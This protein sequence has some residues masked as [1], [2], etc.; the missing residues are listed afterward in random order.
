MIPS[1]TRKPGAVYLVLAALLTVFAARLL[2]TASEKS[3]TV[4][5][6]HYVGTAL[7]LW[8]SGD[9]HFARSL[10]FHPPLTFH[11]AGLPLLAL[12]LGQLEATPRLGGQLMHGSDPAPEL[13]RV[14]SRTPFI[15][16]ACWGAVLLFLWAREVAGT[17]AGLLAAFFY[18]FS[19]TLLANGS[20][21]HSDITVTVFFLQ[22]LYAF[23]R[24]WREPTGFRFGL[25]GLSLG[26]ALMAKLSALLLL[27]ILGILLAGIASQW[28]PLVREPSIHGPAA[29]PVR[30]GWAVGHFL[31]LLSLAVFV[32][33]LGYGGSFALSEG[34][35]GPH[36]SLTLPAYVHS[37]LFDFAANAQGR[38][39]FFFGEYSQQGWWYFLPA[40]YLLKT[41]LGFL[42]LLVFSI[43]SWR[44]SPGR[45]GIFLGT[46]ILVYLLVACVWLKVPLGLRYLLPILPLVNLFVAIRLVPCEAHWKRALVLIGSVWLA[47]A[48]LWI[49]PHYLAYFN[50]LSGGPKRAYRHLVES[51]L[52]WGQ[53]LGTLARYLEA[54][55]NPPVRLAYFGV[56][57]PERYGLRS[58]MLKG[59]KPVTGLV[60]ISASIIQGLYSP[61]NPFKRPPDGCYDWLLEHEPVA[62]PGYSIL[63]YETKQ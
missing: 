13:V 37:L 39:V 42:L 56:E 1:W 45:L 10:R 54:R 28:Q 47:G 57:D 2:H 22:T 38:T 51:N 62:Q 60:A 63:V 3:F 58:T 34:I 24:W 27:P 7:Y 31:G 32:V 19:P 43:S 46:P 17:H 14:L 29:W 55:G 18:T 8:E 41:P 4:D 16:L 25:C 59:C 53:D 50:E 48:S 5:E 6:P 20:L 9:Y 61:G 21:A 30:L 36:A 12:D 49:H 44:R 23:W 15:I 33:W 52:D 26:L 35:G 11:L 40:A